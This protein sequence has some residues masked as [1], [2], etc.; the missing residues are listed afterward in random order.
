MNRIF[1]TLLIIGLAFSAEAQVT[2]SADN[3]CHDKAKYL[4]CF[5][6]LDYKM[7][8]SETTM[9]SFCTLDSSIQYELLNR[10]FK[11]FQRDDTL[12]ITLKETGVELHSFKSD[13][14]KFINVVNNE[15]VGL[16]NMAN[17]NIWP[18]Y[19][20]GKLFSLPIPVIGKGIINIMFYFGIDTKK[21]FWDIIIQGEYKN[22][23]NQQVKIFSDAFNGETETINMCFKNGLSQKYKEESPGIDIFYVHRKDNY[24]LWKIRKV[25][26]TK[27]PGLLTYSDILEYDKKGKLK[28]T[29]F[30]LKGCECK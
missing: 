4:R 10:K 7:K 15:F 23:T 21:L 27:Y 19:N 17:V 11:L 1:S 6:W 29:R 26:E 8:F 22:K 16:F 13:S 5:N 2:I 18:I 24:V 20:E 14:T 28:S 3:I 9:I 25:L 30:D 12:T